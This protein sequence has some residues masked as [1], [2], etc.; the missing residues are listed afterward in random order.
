MQGE[1]YEKDYKQ[2]CTKCNMNCACR[3]CVAEFIDRRCYAG[4]FVSYMN[5]KM[6]VNEYINY[7]PP[8]CG[9]CIMKELDLYGKIIN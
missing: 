2:T 6:K 4:R 7:Y 1:H 9:F 8:Y 3:H 5:L